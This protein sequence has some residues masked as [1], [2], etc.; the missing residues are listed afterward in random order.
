M[1]SSIAGGSAGLSSTAPLSDRRCQDAT[2]RC[3]CWYGRIL[4]LGRPHRVYIGP[5]WYFSIL[6]LIF[7]E[8]S[9]YSYLKSWSGPNHFLHRCGGAI[10]TILTTLSFVWCALA[11]PGIATKRPATEDFN[12]EELKSSQETELES[13]Q[14]GRREEPLSTRRCT[15]CRIPQPRGTVHCHMCQV[16]ISG[17]DH[18]CPWMGKCIGRGSVWKFYSFIIIGF[19]SLGYMLLSSLMEPT[20]RTTTTTPQPYYM[21]TAL[22]AVHNAT[23]LPRV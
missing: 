5:H 15:V 6:M 20:A 2:Q 7:I 10:L 3:Y 9:G 12:D 11:D 1:E 19:S 17:W 13:I 21:P 16:C 22:V 8:C 18:H 23:V 4:A 14:P